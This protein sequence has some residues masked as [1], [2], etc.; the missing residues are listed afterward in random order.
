MQTVDMRILYHAEN[1]WSV[2]ISGKLHSHVSS[3]ALDDLIDHALVAV[4]VAR[5]EDRHP[6]IRRGVVCWS[7]PL[8][9]GFSRSQ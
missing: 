7:T 3:A 1:D 2:W 8:L 6:A 4:E 5:I 9:T